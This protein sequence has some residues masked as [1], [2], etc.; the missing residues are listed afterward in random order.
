MHPAHGNGFPVLKSRY[1]DAEMILAPLFAQAASTIGAGSTLPLSEA[2]EAMLWRLYHDGATSW[3]QIP[4]AAEKFAQFLGRQLPRDVGLEDLVTL[5]ARDLYLVCALGLGD[6]TA[7]TVFESEYMPRVRHALLQFGTSEP[8]IADIKQNLYGRLLEK[9]DVTVVRSGYGGRGDLGSWLCTCAIREAGQRHKKRQRELALEH[10]SEEI[11]RDL[12]SS[13]EVA[14]LTGRLKDVFQESFKEAIA[15]LSSRERNLLRYHFLAELSIDQI[16]AIYHIHRATA[17]RWV[18]KAQE[19][20][21]KK[22]RELFVMRAQVNAESLPRIMELIES[23]LSVNLGNVLK[24]STENDPRADGSTE[25]GGTNG[26]N[27]TGG[28]AS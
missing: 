2:L 22:T 17:A 9:R 7:Q 5:R 12:H 24:G 14:T 11:L 26:T 19:R 10:A 8:G 4:V 13:P 25:P 27:G 23:Q 6:R 1:D 28:A 21:V 3:P 16:G 15:T 18:N 20:L